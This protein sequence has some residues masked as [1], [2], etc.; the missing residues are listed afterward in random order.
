MTK[1]LLFV[2]SFLFSTLAIIAE[3]GNSVSIITSLADLEDIC[4]SDKN[5]TCSLKFTNMLVVYKADNH[6]YISDGQ[7]GMML[8]GASPLVTGQRI[9]G[10]ITGSASLYHG[11]PEL[12]VS[13]ESFHITII[14]ENNDAPSKKVSAFALSLNPR[15]YVNQYIE[16]ENALFQTPYTINDIFRTTFFYSGG[17]HFEL[18]N[19]Y[20]NSWNIDINAHY[21]LR[22]IIAIYDNKVQLTILKSLDLQEKDKKMGNSNIG[23]LEDI[24]YMNAKI[25]YTLFFNDVLVVYKSVNHTY[26][27]DG[28]RGMMLF[29]ASPL[30]TGQRISGSITGSASLYYGTPEL[31]VNEESFNITINSDNNNVP[32]KKISAFALASNP[33]KYANQYVELDNSIFTESYTSN[34]T[35]RSLSFSADNYQFLLFNLYNNKMD[36]VANKPY[37]IRGV[38]AVYENDVQLTLLKGTDLFLS[39]ETSIT[40]P[41]NQ[42]INEENYTLSGCRLDYPKKGLNIIKKQDGTVQKRV[43]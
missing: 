9:S 14:S 10:S 25:P 30:S 6:T 7:R 24:C 21:Q 5:A 37:V 13:D 42:N 1:R 18:F 12:Q 36:I 29:G 3:N 28:Q 11:T 26:I 16:V 43:M 19:L 33:R 17:Y 4:Y 23:E 15:K 27:S 38:L 40:V 8:F 32:C 34:K 31:Q 35:F 41:K 22:G 39:E 20:N 2:I